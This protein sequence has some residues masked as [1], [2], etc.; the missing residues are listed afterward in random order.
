MYVQPSPARFHVEDRG[1]RTRI[2]LPSRK[3]WFAMAFMCVWLAGWAFGEVTVLGVLLA[4]R[5]L[6]S[7]S[8]FLLFWLTGWTVGGALVFA[9]LLWQLAGSE[10]IEV[11]GEALVVWKSVLGVRF[12]PKAYA[13]EHIQDLRVPVMEASSNLFGFG[14][15]HYLWGAGP[16]AI[17]FDYGAKTIRIASGAD[18]AE[19]KLIVGTI[20]QRYP[21]Y[22]RV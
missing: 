9:T 1:D 6:A 15:R 10:T 20:R 22:R 5:E 8:A 17:A 18:E 13:I 12:P 4:G 3:M 14:R 11:T 19:A 7:G 16:G 2:V 21:A